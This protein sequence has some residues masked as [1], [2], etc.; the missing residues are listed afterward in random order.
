VLLVNTENE[1]SELIAT[2]A[3]LQMPARI[4]N[5][6]ENLPSYAAL[7]YDDLRQ[8]DADQIRTLIAVLPVNIGLGAAIIDRLSK[9]A[10]PVDGLPAS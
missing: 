9:A 2:L 6:C 5:R 7:L 10:A 4:I 8:A 1:A 3:P